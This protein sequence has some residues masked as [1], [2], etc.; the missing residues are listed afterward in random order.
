MSEK[1]PSTTERNL[2]FWQV[3]DILIQ[4]SAADDDREKIINDA[5]NR[6]REKWALNLSCMPTAVPELLRKI[7]D[8][9][10]NHQLDD[11]AKN[12]LLR[13]WIP[14]A[15]VVAN[16]QDAAHRQ[17]ITAA[18]GLSHLRDAKAIL[19]QCHLE[20]D[21][22]LPDWPFNSDPSITG[23]SYYLDRFMFTDFL[24]RMPLFS[25]QIGNAMEILDRHM[26]RRRADSDEWRL[27]FATILGCCWFRYR[28]KPPSESGQFVEFLNDVTIVVRLE[29]TEWKRTIR[30]MCNQVDFETMDQDIWL[31]NTYPQVWSQIMDGNPSFQAMMS[32]LAADGRTLND[33]LD[34]KEFEGLLLSKFG[35]KTD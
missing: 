25:L 24:D 15:F 21:G 4:A 16:H 31:A 20:L 34:N 11:S 12:E 29:C 6:L 13:F 28:K 5:K 10:E 35:A 26:Q 7:A 3:R 14:F 27:A 30:N 23:G 17:K 33:L 22:V 8:V 1:S 2:S 32:S 9:P 19:E 18:Q